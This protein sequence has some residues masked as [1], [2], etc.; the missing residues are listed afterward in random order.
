M[1]RQVG[2]AM[3]ISTTAPAIA[4]PIW[5]EDLRRFGRQRFF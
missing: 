5:P 1:S 2:M 3:A 4:H